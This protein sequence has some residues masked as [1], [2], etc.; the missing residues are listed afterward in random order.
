MH[1]FHLVK[2]GE[3]F[4]LLRIYNV[5]LI[6]KYSITVLGKLARWEKEQPFVC[7]NNTST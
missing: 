1:I 6:L 5:S 7:D 3:G 2:R 4:D